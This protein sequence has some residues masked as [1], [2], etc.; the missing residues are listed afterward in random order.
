M[1]SPRSSQTGGGLESDA[2]SSQLRKQVDKFEFENA[3]LKNELEANNAHLQE[4]LENLKYAKDST[5]VILEDL[6]TDKEK[7]ML[8]I[9]DK[10]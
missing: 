3:K 6:K 8:V 1:F 2:V 4:T 7:L 9:E 5:K 10:N